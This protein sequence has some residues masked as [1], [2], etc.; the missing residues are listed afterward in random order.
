MNKILN[1][2]F[3]GKQAKAACD[4]VTNQYCKL[5]GICN[6]WKKKIW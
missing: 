4:C 3:V 5:R 6:P 2:V 1:L